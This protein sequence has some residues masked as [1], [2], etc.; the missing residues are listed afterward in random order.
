MKRLEYLIVGFLITVFLIV[1]CSAQSTSQSSISSDD[2]APELYGFVYDS[3]AS[4]DDSV[5]EKPKTTSTTINSRKKHLDKH[6]INA[7]LPTITLPPLKQQEGRPRKEQ[8]KEAL[9]N[10]FDESVLNVATTT[11]TLSRL[12][13]Y[14]EDICFVDLDA[15]GD[16]SLEC[17]SEELHPVCAICRL[18]CVDYCMEG[19]FG[20]QSCF[21]NSEG[22]PFCQCTNRAPQCYEL[23]AEASQEREYADS[24]DRILFFIF[25]GL[26]MLFVAAVAIHYAY[27]KV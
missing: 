14:S 9:I 10:S 5:D 16:G 4:I 20:L 21:N 7:S 12:C 23:S 25:V 1:S 17:C 26:M 6:G 3:V 24:G 8:K 2:F 18:H 15:E 11:T 19:G 13:G 27:R 22:K